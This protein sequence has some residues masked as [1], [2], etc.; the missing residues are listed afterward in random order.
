MSEELKFDIAG[1]TSVRFP[2]AGKFCDKNIVV[3]AIGG[4][5]TDAALESIWKVV[6]ER[7]SM[8]TAVIPN[9]VTRIGFH[10]FASCV[11]LASVRLPANLI[12][13]SPYAFYCCYALKS[14]ELPATLETIDTQAFDM[15]GLSSV[16]IPVSVKTIGTKAFSSCNSLSRITFRGKPESI[17]S[18]AFSSCTNLTYIYTPWKRGEVAGAPWGA[19]NAEIRYSDYDPGLGDEDF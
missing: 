3:N 15:A 11:A 17:A 4:S 8:T 2:T 14:I 9:S 10:A 7:R 19:T 18:N 5:D 16:V 13:I 12:E 6:A 1:G